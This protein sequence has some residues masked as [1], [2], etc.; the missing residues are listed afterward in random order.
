MELIASS[1]IYVDF[2]RQLCNHKKRDLIDVSAQQ[3][4]H[5]LL[6][7]RLSDTEIEKICVNM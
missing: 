2:V 1:C 4:S 6:L 7:F 3:R 5:Y